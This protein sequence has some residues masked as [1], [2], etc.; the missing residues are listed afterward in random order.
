MIKTIKNKISRKE[1]KRISVRTLG[2]TWY[3]NLKFVW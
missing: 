1:E 2:I 3:K